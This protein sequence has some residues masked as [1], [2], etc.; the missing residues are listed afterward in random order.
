MQIAAQLQLDDKPAAAGSCSLNVEE[1][2]AESA[3]TVVNLPGLT[4][5]A[6][7]TGGRV[8]DPAKPD[9]WP[10]PGT[11]AVR[12]VER[13]HAVD[14]WSNFTLLFVLVGLLAI[15]WFVRVFRGLT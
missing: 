8:L 2:G 12:Q 15:D 14:P 6:Q 3:D 1:P 5:L 10:Q 4:R 9:T 13:T 11:G 7:A